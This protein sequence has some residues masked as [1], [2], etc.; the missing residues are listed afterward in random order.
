MKNLVKVQDELKSVLNKYEKF[1][2]IIV[3]GCY[4]CHIRIYSNDNVLFSTPSLKDVMDVCD[5]NNRVICI[6]DNYAQIF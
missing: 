5:K 2:V 6:I 4:G 3:S 1:D